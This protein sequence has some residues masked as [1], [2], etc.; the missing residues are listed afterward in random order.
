MKTKERSKLGQGETRKT[1]I[2]IP[3][4]LFRAQVAPRPVST[5]S[6]IPATFILAYIIPTQETLLF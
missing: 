6:D 1:Y 2:W 5:K 4:E 3:Q